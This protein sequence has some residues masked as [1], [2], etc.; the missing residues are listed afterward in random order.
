MRDDYRLLSAS[1]QAE[2]SE[3]S[4]FFSAALIFREQERDSART[5]SDVMPLKGDNTGSH[6]VDPR[7]PDW[8]RERVGGAVLQ[9][10]QNR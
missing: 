3:L 1:V 2:R 5:H 9:F 7:M 8:Q 10:R 6:R 4:A